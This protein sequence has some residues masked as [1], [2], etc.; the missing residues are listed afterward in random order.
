MST[1]NNLQNLKIDFILLRLI[2]NMDDFMSDKRE[3]TKSD[4]LR[5]LIWKCEAIKSNA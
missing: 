3:K 2:Y 5:S 4:V 1:Y